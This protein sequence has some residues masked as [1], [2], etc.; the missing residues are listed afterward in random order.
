MD[1]VLLSDLERYYI[2][3]GAELGCRSDGRAPDEFRPLE[4][5]TGILSHATGS[6]RVRLGETHIMGCVKMEVGKPLPNHHDEGRIEINVECYPTATRSANERSA[7]EI[8]ENLQATLQSAY[9]SDLF[10]LKS[11]CIEPGR[12]CWTVYV[13]LLLLEGGGNFLDA[14]SIVIK[15]AFVDATRLSDP[16]KPGNIPSREQRPTLPYFDRKLLP[17][18][19]TVHKVG[20]AYLVDASKEEEACSLS[21]LSVVVYSD[22][23]T[24]AFFLEGC[25]SCHCET[26][27]GM[28][29]LARSVGMELTS[30]LRKCMQLEKQLKS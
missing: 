18:F 26:I 15:A 5:E 19:V 13:D 3:Q 2:I 28:C 6:A 16:E 20:N 9:R 25:G 10:D 7:K 22:G 4:M 27:L 11:L 24:G 23:S 30:A 17:I 29:E 12:Q 8:A 1:C 21:R 14:A